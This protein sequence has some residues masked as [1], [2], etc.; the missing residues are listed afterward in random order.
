[1][2]EETEEIKEDEILEEKEEPTEPIQVVIK[3]E[4][5]I[6]EA[7]F[8]YDDYLPTDAEIQ[9]T[10]KEINENAEKRKVKNA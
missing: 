5:P 2:S 6:K 4:E 10:E 8:D 9:E 7:D 1:M 3:K